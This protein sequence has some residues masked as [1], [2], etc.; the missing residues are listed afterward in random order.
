MNVEIRKMQE[1]DI[2]QARML[3][4]RVPGISL[5]SVD[6]PESLV[7]F[8]QENPKTCFVASK[9]NQ[10]IG[11]VLGGNDG[12]RGFIY[13]LAVHP[14]FQRQGI[15]SELTETCLNAFRQLGI[16]KCHIFVLNDNSEGIA[17]WK[18]VGWNL[19]EDIL[20]LSKDL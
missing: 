15:G 18:H 10:L 12:R 8:L 3:W 1:D 19:R 2:A 4:E 9:H 17:F 7:V 13:H 5:S 11:T 20:I 14:E 16:R 6:A